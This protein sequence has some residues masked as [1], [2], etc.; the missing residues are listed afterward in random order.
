MGSGERS[1]PTT[2]VTMSST[3]LSSATQNTTGLCANSRN[4]KKDTRSLLRP[5]PRPDAWAD[6]SPSVSAGSAIRADGE[7]GEETTANLRTVRSLPRRIPVDPGSM[8]VPRHL[9]VRGEAIIFKRDFD[10]M[11]RRL[12][13]ASERTYVNPTN[14]ASGTLRQLDSSLTAARPIPLLCHAL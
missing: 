12:L 9:V 10:E 3:R 4:S 7:F 14:T 13:E 5:T 6:G 11:N 2:T 8:K 1:P